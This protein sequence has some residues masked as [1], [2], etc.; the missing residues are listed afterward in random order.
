MG[1]SRGGLITLYSAM[2]RF[3]TA[4]NESGVTPAAYV[5][6]YPVCNFQFLGDT[7]VAGGP[8]R[9]FHGAAD[10]YVPIGP[11]QDYVQRL[12]QAGKDAEITAMPGAYH[13]YDM[14]VLPSQPMFLANAQT[15]NCRIVEDKS[16]AMLD[17]ATGKPWAGADP[18]NGVGAHLAYSAEATAATEKAVIDFLGSVF[19]LK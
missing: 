18:C 12:R 7:E 14:T 2:K 6:L 10:D 5:P 8:I 3:Q 17:T 15:T 13:A 1:F 4:W 9:I 16:G 19:K 11:C